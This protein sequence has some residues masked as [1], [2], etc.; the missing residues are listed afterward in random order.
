[1]LCLGNSG[2]GTLCAQNVA[3][4]VTAEAPDPSAMLDIAAEN[5]GLLLPRLGFT[6]T[7]DVV[8][9]PSPAIALL[10]YNTASASISPNNVV[11][12]FYFWNGTKWVP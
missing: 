6:S 2:S 9:I 7:A 8:T 3:I 5:K 4:N 11:P 12:R 1:M 10:V